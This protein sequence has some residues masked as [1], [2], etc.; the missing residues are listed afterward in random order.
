MKA[1]IESSARDVAVQ[2]ERV[3]VDEAERLASVLRLGLLDTP[4]AE[5]FDAVARLAAQRGP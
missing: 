5:Y 1:A 3:P 4:P 2:N